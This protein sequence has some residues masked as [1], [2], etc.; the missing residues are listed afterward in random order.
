MFKITLLKTKYSTFNLITKCLAIVVQL[1]K[2]INGFC[3]KMKLII[4]NRYIY[5]N[6]IS[7]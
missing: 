7:Y 6:N 4:I 1:N 5:K 3:N 2:C